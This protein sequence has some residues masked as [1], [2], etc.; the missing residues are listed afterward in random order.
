MHL[1]PPAYVITTVTEE[2]SN[3]LFIVRYVGSH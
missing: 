1:E 3:M 2:M